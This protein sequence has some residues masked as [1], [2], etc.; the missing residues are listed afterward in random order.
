MHRKRAGSRDARSR[1]R[2]GEKEVGGENAGGDT[3]DLVFQIK[4]L[5]P[6]RAE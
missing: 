4:Y 2:K 1:E 6:R 3:L 5:K